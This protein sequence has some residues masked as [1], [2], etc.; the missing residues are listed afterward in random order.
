MFYKIGVLTNFP[1]FPG[2]L[3]GILQEVTGWQP[4]IWQ[5]V[6]LFKKRLRYRRFSINFANFL[7]T[8]IL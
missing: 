3:T 6:T 7:R 2:K 5:P 8:T 4:V 1:K